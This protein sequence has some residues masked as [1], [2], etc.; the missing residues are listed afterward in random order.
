[1][2][3]EHP[4]IAP[5]AGFRTGDGL[6]VLAVGTD[7][8]FQSLCQVIGAPSLAQ[9]PRFATNPERVA[10]REALRRDLEMLLAGHPAAWWA[11]RLTEARVP[12]GVVND[13][14]A[15][16]ALAETLGLDPLIELPTPDGSSI[17]L[18]RNP[19]RM[20]E[21]PPSYRTAPPELPE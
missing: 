21:T 1:M 4:S 8:Q 3:N 10:N 14:A 9:D 16:F 20:S 15:A 13:I 12:A 17:R 19:I 2:G 5:Y 11:A 18:P 7:R 6:L